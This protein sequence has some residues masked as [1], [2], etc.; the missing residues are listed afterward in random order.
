[1][2][3][4]SQLKYKDQYCT[5]FVIRQI[6]ALKKYFD[7][8]NSKRV[9]AFDWWCGR[10]YFLCEDK[11]YAVDFDYSFKESNK[12]VVA[13]AYTATIKNHNIVDFKVVLEDDTTPRVEEF[14]CI[15]TYVAKKILTEKDVK[16]WYDSLVSV[17]EFVD[18]PHKKAIQFLQNYKK[19]TFNQGRYLFYAKRDNDLTWLYFVYAYDTKTK[20]ELKIY[21]DSCFDTKFP[22]KL[23]QIYVQDLSGKLSPYQILQCKKAFFKYCKQECKELKAPNF[24][25]MEFVK[26]CIQPIEKL[27]GWFASKAKCEDSDDFEICVDD[28]LMYDEKPYFLVRK[29]DKTKVAALDFYKPEYKST[30]PYISGYNKFLH[31][32]MDKEILKKLVKFLHKKYDYRN[33]DYYKRY[34]GKPTCNKEYTNWQKIIE[35]YNENTVKN[36]EYY[37]K[38]P[39]DLSI[40]DYT[41]LAKE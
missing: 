14:D 34:G 33:T 17:N 10:Y 41:K 37:I 20:T 1:M 22:E 21:V 35:N 32:D 27:K 3:V 5:E 25:A 36:K 18:V 16:L 40:P 8:S 38:L 31:W 2:S 39:M 28:V 30:K 24:Y 13:S 29:K 6:E 26:Q 7:I 19:D 15:K 11:I 9:Y 4:K 23:N 12:P